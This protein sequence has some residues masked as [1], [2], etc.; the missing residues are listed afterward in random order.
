[1]ATVDPTGKAVAVTK[2]GWDNG[3][4]PAGQGL[5]QIQ[6][7]RG[8]DADDRRSLK[9]GG[10]AGRLR[11]ARRDR[12]SQAVEVLG[13][14]AGRPELAREASRTPGE[15]SNGRRRPQG[16]GRVGALSGLDLAG[17]RRGAVVKAGGQRREA[18]QGADG[19]GGGTGSLK[20]DQKAGDG[21][22]ACTD[23]GDRACACGGRD[24]K[25]RACVDD[26]GRAACSWGAGEPV[27]VEATTGKADDHRREGGR[28]RS[29]RPGWQRR[30]PGWR[31]WRQP[32]GL[33][34]RRGWGPR[35]W[36]TW[37]QGPRPR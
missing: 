24:S 13:A 35:L 1:V 14:S 29:R 32:C 22:A 27:P 36:R 33:R 30:E 37:R 10:T 34:R 9:V 5:H 11:R 4:G 19:L 12:C 21:R 16:R 31:R 3:A 23:E 8:V 18:G 25:G 28:A 26:G 20:T 2:K 15:P 7:D 17:Q 6:P